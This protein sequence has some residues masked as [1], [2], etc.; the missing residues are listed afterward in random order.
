MTVDSRQSAATKL[1]LPARCSRLTARHTGNSFA[2]VAQVVDVPLLAPAPG[3]VYI[4][5]RLS[6]RTL[7]QEIVKQADM[8]PSGG[9]ESQLCGRERRLRDL[10][11]EGRALVYPLAWSQLS[12]QIFH[13]EY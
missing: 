3:E 10:P 5:I 2:E 4:Y 13:L 6:Y 9:C 12:N 8:A 11:G 1:Q 7:R